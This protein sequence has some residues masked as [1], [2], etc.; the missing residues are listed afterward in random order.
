MTPF[1]KGIKIF[2]ISLAVFIICIIVSS[3]M[4]AFHLMF[5]VTGGIND[6]GHREVSTYNFDDIKYLDIDLG[7]VNLEIREGNEFKIET[8]NSNIDVRSKNNSVKIEE[9][10]WFFWRT[11]TGTVT[12]YIPKNSLD[13]TS[14]DVGAGKVSIDGL[15]TD[16]FDLDH[17]AGYVSIENSNFSRVDIDGGAGKIDIKNST[18][19]NLNFDTGVG[20]TNVSN[21]K[22]LGKSEISVGVGSVKLDLNDSIEDYTIETDKGLGS[23]KINGTETNGKMGSG[24]NHLDVDGGVGSITIDFAN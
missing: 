2:A 5:W 7:G 3:I 22:L 12:V 8:D 18:L 15:Y 9:R 24:P 11:H 19:R 6:N 4:S 16:S 14:I 1:Q 13:E 23:I 20:S 10:S 21:S 17:G